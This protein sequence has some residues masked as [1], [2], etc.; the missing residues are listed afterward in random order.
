MPLAKQM[1]GDH[2]GMVVDKF[3][4]QWMVNIAGG[5]ELT[6]ADQG[7]ADRDFPEP[8]QQPGA[9]RAEVFL[10]YLAYYRAVLAEKVQGLSDEDL[11]GSRLPSGWAPIELLKHLQHVELRWLE[12]GFEGRE[13]EDPW[14]DSRDQRWHVAPDETLGD[15]LAAL[16]AQAE[17]TR[18]VVLR[19]DLGEV[20]HRASDGTVTSPPTL[21]RIL[22]HLLQEYARHVGHLDVVR[23][24]HRRDGGECA[25]RRASVVVVHLV[26][27]GVTAAAGDQPAVDRH[28]DHEGHGQRQGEA[29]PEERAGQAG[30]HGA[31][32]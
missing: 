11:R 2:F 13:V 23:R 20:G 4:I 17:R 5:D 3:G 15:L 25:L 10:R 29:A 24:A 6:A 32:G 12:W 18:A 22:F 19:H 8:T 9:S 16:S 7:A 28:R 14:A 1:W 31:R 27:H 21:E 26:H 30:V